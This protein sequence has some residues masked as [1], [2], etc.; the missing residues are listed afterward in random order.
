MTSESF[1]VNGR[2]LPP[3]LIHGVARMLIELCAG[4]VGWRV[5]APPRFR[6]EVFFRGRTDTAEMRGAGL[7]VSG[8][9]GLPVRLRGL[10]APSAIGT[11]IAM[12]E[13]AESHPQADYRHDSQAAA[14]AVSGIVWFLLTCAAVAALFH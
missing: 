5:M 2:T 14:F 6:R 10:V 3:G 12:R 8:S 1:P 4:P 9:C 13:A 7:R 11:V